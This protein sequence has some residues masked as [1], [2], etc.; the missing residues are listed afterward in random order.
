MIKSRYSI[1]YKKLTR[2]Q[3]N[4]NLS[5]PFLRSIISK[6]SSNFCEHNT[7][8]NYSD[9]YTIAQEALWKAMI[10]YDTKKGP[11]TSYAAFVCRREIMN[12]YNLKRHKQLAKEVPLDE[13]GYNLIDHTKESDLEAD[14]NK[15]YIHQLLNKISNK[16]RIFLKRIIAKDISPL[17]VWG[18]SYSA[19]KLRM[20]TF[21]F[22]KQLKNAID[23]LRITALKNN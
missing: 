8:C 16:N 18:Q 1:P 11:F 15:I 2:N 10:S 9:I 12:H 20:S 13:A 7:S 3:T 14:E 6:L 4:I 21:K 19:K 22:K 5:G 23:E 17:D